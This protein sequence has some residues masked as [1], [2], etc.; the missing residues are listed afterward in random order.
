MKEKIKNYFKQLGAK[1]KSKPVQ[2][3]LSCILMIICIGLILFIFLYPK[4][5]N[6]KC[7]CTEFFSTECSS[8]EYVDKLQEPNAVNYDYPNGD[9]SSE[10]I[11]I[12]PVL[13]ASEIIPMELFNALPTTNYLYRGQVSW[14]YSTTIGT[15]FQQQDSMRIYRD[16]LSVL[17]YTS[18]ATI[19][20][21]NFVAQGEGYRC[22]G[23]Q[24]SS[25]TTNPSYTASSQVCYLCFCTFPTGTEN[26]VAISKLFLKLFVSQM[27]NL[28]VRDAT[29]SGYDIG[30]SDGLEEGKQQGYDLGYSTGYSKGS[31]GTFNPV[32]MIINPVAQFLST[33]LFGNFSIGSF[34]TVA[35]FVSVALIFLRIFAGG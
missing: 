7:S 17:C 2:F 28:G 29:D 30:Y 26:N 1:I 32:G 11:L 18:S 9:S 4:Y 3:L 10:A 13:S 12:F 31:D 23:L 14:R 22:T 15:V 19:W 35:L 34:F 27:Y 8:M 16:G 20:K 5:Y 24:Y 21:F 25:N 6:E 33:P